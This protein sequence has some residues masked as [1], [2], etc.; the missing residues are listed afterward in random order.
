M[1]V[2]AKINSEEI[3]TDDFVRLLKLHGK[4]DHIMEDIIIERLAVHSARK[5]GLTVSP[6]E[7]QAKFDQIRRIN[8]LHR[9]KAT[10]EFLQHLGVTLDE[11]ESYLTDMIYKEKIIGSITTE[12]AIQEYFSLNSPDFDH[13]EVAHIVLDS[14]G[15]ARE[16]I[17][18]LEEDPDSFGQLA[19]EHSLD[20][21]TR[22]NGGSIGAVQRGSLKP[23]IEARIFNADEGSIHGPFTSSDGRFFELF[24]VNNI[25]A[26]SLDEATKDKVQKQVYDNWLKDRANE[27]R[28]EIL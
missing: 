14:E 23:D 4:F 1:T 19:R 6:E 2:L 10:S 22:E 13:V 27:S 28:I 25:H 18:I 24:T 12:S 15:K 5:M 17:S 21:D 11:F 20:S 16:I 7:I 9:A 26:A 3:G 8:G